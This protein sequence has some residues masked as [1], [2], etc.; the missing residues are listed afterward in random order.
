MRHK[1]HRKECRRL[2]AN[3]GSVCESCRDKTAE[4]RR[5]RR[6]A[7]KRQTGHRV[8]KA[9]AADER[10]AIRER[11]IFD[12]LRSGG[13]RETFVTEEAAKRSAARVP[14]TVTPRT[15]FDAIAFRCR[16]SD[17][18]R[19][20]MNAGELL[21]MAATEAAAEAAIRERRERREGS[22]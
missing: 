4:R 17:G 20:A 9:P 13:R 1:C 16:D 2:V 6:A 18:L 5:E 12:V 10:Y 11:T 7:E 3:R 21:A 19:Q 15:V 8:S 22:P 14:G